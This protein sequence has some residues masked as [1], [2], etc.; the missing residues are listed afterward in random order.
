MK[1]IEQK[2]V[3]YLLIGIVAVA[4]GTSVAFM[5]DCLFGAEAGFSFSATSAATVAIIVNFSVNCG[6]VPSDVK[7]IEQMDGEIDQK[8][9]R[10]NRKFTKLL[11]GDYETD[12]MDNRT[13]HIFSDPT[14]A[15]C[16]ANTKPFPLQTYKRDTSEVMHDLSV[17]IHV[18][19][20]HWG[21]FRI[22]YRS[23]APTATV[24][25]KANDKVP[26]IA[27]PQKVHNGLRT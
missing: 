16:G 15:R 17:P 8:F 1:R 20:M 6:T 2:S 3:R 5:T 18:N 14:G 25:A 10:H 7:Y 26:A 24:E 13:K 27:L 11:T 4:V 12:L 9:P 23:S 19:G 22:G 21:G